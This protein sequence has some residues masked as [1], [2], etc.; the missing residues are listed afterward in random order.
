MTLRHPFSLQRIAAAALALGLAG[1]A[2]ASNYYVVIPVKGRTEAVAAAGVSV[3]LSPAALPTGAEGK[4]YA[5]FDFNTALQVTG[6]PNFSG[7]GIT[8]RLVAGALPPGMTLSADG[9]LAGTPTSG[10]TAAFSVQATYRTKAGQQAYQVVVTQLTVGLSQATLPAGLEGE[11]YPGFDFNTAL[12]VTGDADF[13]AAGVTWSVVDGVLPAGLVLSPD[14]RLS[15]TP[16]AGGTSTFSVRASYRTKAGQQAY[17]V[18]VNTLT[19]A[20][21]GGRMPVAP[22]GASYSFDFK[23]QLS[24]SGDSNYDASKVSWS[25]VGTLPTGLTLSATGLLSGTP[26]LDDAGAQVTV[27]AAYK[28]K[29]GQQTYTVFPSDP[30]FSNVGLLMH[31]DGANGSTSF[32]DAKGHAFAASG[33]PT[34][35]TASSKFGGASARFNGSSYLQT[36]Y[37]PAFA[38][39]FTVELWA[40]ISAHKDYGGLIGASTPTNPLKGWQLI[41]DFTADTIRFEGE[42][43]AMVSS[44]PLPLNTW[45]HIALVRQGMAANNVRLYINGSLVSSVT[46]TGTFDNGGQPLYIGVDRTAAKT[47]TG[48]IDDVR[49]TNNVARYTGN[50]T[51]PAASHPS[52]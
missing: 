41:F 15:G 17:Q 21:T 29:S 35:S 25:A 6:D 40:N 13:S 44:T 52:R 26:V 2:A 39:D 10:G 27:K 47:V 1:S 31:L 43:V 18:L 48:Y 23:Q 36:G 32:V 51:P 50:F 20:L 42:S 33:A 24:V 5:G 22:V 9:H 4:P 14:G 11:A 8:W 45:A 34:I 12:Q 19:V 37:A 49:I 46:Y 28:T 38:G 7:S 30:L 16:T 3:T